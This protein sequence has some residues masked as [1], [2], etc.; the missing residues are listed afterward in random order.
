MAVIEVNE[1]SPTRVEITRLISE[2]DQ[3]ALSLY[4]PKSNHLPGAEDLVAAG[5]RFFVARA[6]GVIVGCAALLRDGTE[7]EVK[8]MFVREHARGMGVGRAILRALEDA[9]RDDGVNV[10]RLESGFRNAEALGLFRRVG[11][12]DR[13]PFGAHRADPVS[14]FMEKHL[15]PIE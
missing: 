10:L 14:V 8:R 6:D 2:A 12:I 13:G 15:S 4:P 3:Y 9:A 1:E 11:F 7:G 5:A